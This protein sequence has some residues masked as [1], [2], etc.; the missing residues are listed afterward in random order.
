MNKTKLF[1]QLA[2]IFQMIT[3]YVRSSDPDFFILGVG[4]FLVGLLALQDKPQ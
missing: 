4:L 1:L 3:N 2:I